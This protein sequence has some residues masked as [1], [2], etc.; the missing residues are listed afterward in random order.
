MYNVGAEGHYVPEGKKKKNFIAYLEMSERS[1]IKLSKTIEPEEKAPVISSRRSK[2][3]EK[4]EN[5]DISSHGSSS[6]RTNNKTSSSP[7][8]CKFVVCFPT[9]QLA[10]LIIFVSIAKSTVNGSPVKAPTSVPP[11]PLKSPETTATTPNATTPVSVSANL[12]YAQA[13]AT[14]A[15]SDSPTSPAKEKGKTNDE[16]INWFYVLILFFSI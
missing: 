2:R 4:D 10:F 8:S 9:L 13:A 3:E 12:K 11:P 7:T 6:T 16:R 14:A 5:D 1:C 15:G